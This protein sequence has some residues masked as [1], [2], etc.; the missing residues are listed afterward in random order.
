M[1]KDQIEEIKKLVD[2]EIELEWQKK[3][4]FAVPCSNR[5]GQFCSRG[6]FDAD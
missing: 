2:E 3:R 1:H 4:Y 5:V 6:L